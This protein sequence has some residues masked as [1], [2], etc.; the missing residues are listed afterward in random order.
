MRAH[1]P[2]QSALHTEH[3]TNSIVLSRPANEPAPQLH[4]FPINLGG[5]ADYDAGH[6]IVNWYNG[7]DQ[8]REEYAI[9]YAELVGPAFL[10]DRLPTAHDS[11]GLPTADGACV[12]VFKHCPHDTTGPLINASVVNVLL[13]CNCLTYRQVR[14]HA[15]AHWLSRS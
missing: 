10:E 7:D 9:I 4:L 6:G 1:G 3:A 15:G 8:E 14:P 5:S 11:E 13:H 2:V 12:R